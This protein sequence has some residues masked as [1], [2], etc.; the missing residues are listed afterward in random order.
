MPVYGQHG[1]TILNQHL[2]SG[3]PLDDI[4]L[5][6][7]SLE[8]WSLENREMKGLS[9]RRSILDGSGF[10]KV[11]F[12]DSV[13]EESNLKGA[14]FRAC[15]LDSV[16]FNS[17]ILLRSGFSGCAF[18][19]GSFKRSL[20]QRTAFRNCSL[21]DMLFLNVEAG[22][23]VVEKC[24]FSGCDFLFE[25]SGGITGFQGSVFSDSIFIN[26]TFQG[27]ALTGVEMKNCVFIG[28]GFALPDWEDIDVDDV[29][30]SFCSGIPEWKR[31]VRP[32]LEELGSEIEAAR[33]LAEIRGDI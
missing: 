17:C 19:G 22:K 25:D 7:I 9:C 30:F 15:S 2:E 11:G 20:M 24:A 13:F 10:T 26:C 33:F 27:F 31:T 23:N 1:M 28:T 14:S 5:N 6:N 29:K 16:N 12:E 32:G 21:S 18:T 3:K 4:Q 8:N